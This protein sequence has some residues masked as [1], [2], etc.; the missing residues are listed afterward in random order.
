MQNIYLF[1]RPKEFTEDKGE[2]T[3][4]K[5]ANPEKDKGDEK[6][7]KEGGE[8]EGEGE[9]EE[10]GDDDDLFVNPNHQVAPES[11]DESDENED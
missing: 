8:G 2:E 1:I 9:E 7:A 11:D 10:S 5:Q 6:D 4:V 3:T